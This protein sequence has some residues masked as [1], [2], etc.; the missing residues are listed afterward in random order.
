MIYVFDF[1][2]SAST[3]AT[4]KKKT[5]LP[6]THGLIYKLDILFPPGPAHLLHLQIKDALQFVWPTNPDQDFAGDNEQITFEDEYPITEPP[7]ELQAYTWN[8]DDTFDH[9]IIIRIGVNPIAIVPE[10]RIREL[11]QSWQ[12]P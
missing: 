2:T 4:T 10:V 1:E 6:L 11:L 3:L 12:V 9:R 7:Y 8:I 5:L